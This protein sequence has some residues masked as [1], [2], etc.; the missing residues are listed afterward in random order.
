[1]PQDSGVWCWSLSECVAVCSYASWLWVK[2][3]TEWLTGILFSSKFYDNWWL[4]N[5]PLSF[6]VHCSS[7]LHKLYICGNI[8]ERNN[9]LYF[10]V[11]LVRKRRMGKKWRKEVEKTTWGHKCMRQQYTILHRLW[12]NSAK[13]QLS[14]WQLWSFVQW[15]MYLFY[16][17]VDL[18]NIH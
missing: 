2:G 8:I 17:I 9:Y 4:M 16:Q 14:E 10:S 6:I 5:L 1:M 11:I 3:W 13:N 18:S 7:I 15:L 12:F